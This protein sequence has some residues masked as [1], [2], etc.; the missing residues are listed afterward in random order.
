MY[1]TDIFGASLNS[2]ASKKNYF[3]VSL[4]HSSSLLASVPVTVT[5][6]SHVSLPLSPVADI[7]KEKNYTTVGLLNIL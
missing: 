1:A 5:E 4:L 3:H 2:S 7:K 6:Y